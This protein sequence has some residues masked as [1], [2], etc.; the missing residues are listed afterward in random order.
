MSSALEQ[1]SG[2]NDYQSH[3]RELVAKFSIT[4]NATPANKKHSVDISDS[5]TLKT[6]G[7]DDITAQDPLTG[8]TVLTPS[9]ANGTML[10][11]IESLNASSIKRFAVLDGA[12]VQIATSAQITAL[13]N[14]VLEIDGTDDFATTSVTY[15]ID[16]NYQAGK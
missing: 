12:G 7:K 9:D 8:L 1:N 10:I 2:L 13:G 15:T 6:Q 4:F 16:L 3:S 14:I 5:M 11:L